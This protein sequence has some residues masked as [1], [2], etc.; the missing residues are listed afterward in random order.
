MIAHKKMTG[1]PL[2]VI[3]ASLP[4]NLVYPFRNNILVLVPEIEHV[5]EDHYLRCIFS[6]KVQESNYLSFPDKATFIVWNAKVKVGQKIYLFP[7]SR[8]MPTICFA[9]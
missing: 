3:S 2:S 8:F 1:I 4:S 7:G 5:A 6:G 9:V